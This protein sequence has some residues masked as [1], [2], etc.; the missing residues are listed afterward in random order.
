MFIAWITFIILPQLRQH[1]NV[2]SPSA[3][4]I[5]VITFRGIP[6]ST[7]LVESLSGNLGDFSLSYS[8]EDKRIDSSFTSALSVRSH[9]MQFI[10]H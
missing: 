3:S 7:S 1:C 4:K 9:Y 10:C 8:N 2:N 6:K 5:F